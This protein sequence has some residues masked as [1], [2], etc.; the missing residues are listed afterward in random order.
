MNKLGYTKT[1]DSFWNQEN[2]SQDIWNMNKPKLLHQM[3]VSRHKW[4]HTGW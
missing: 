3:N 4:A 2:Y 1:M